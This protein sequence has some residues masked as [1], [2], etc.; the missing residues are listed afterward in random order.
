[1]STPLTNEEVE[2]IE[3]LQRAAR[4][5]THYD[6]LEIDQSAPKVEVDKAYKD[7]VRIWHPD[8][9]FRRDLGE[10]KAALDEN[11]GRLTEAHETLMN[12]SKRS[13]YDRELRRKGLVPV[14]RPS[15]SIMEP[16][17]EEVIEFRRKGATVEIVPSRGGSTPTVASPP[18]AP[19]FLRDLKDQVAQRMAKARVYFEG[20][21]ES[22][23]AANWPQAENNFYLATRYDP[24]NPEYVEAH[25]NAVS[26]SRVGRVAMC[27]Q[28]GDTAASYGRFKE[29]IA[30]Y[31][32][33]C[34]FEPTNGTAY[35]KLGQLLMSTEDDLR[36]A[37]TAW[38]KAAQLEPRN[39]AYHW[40]L[41]EAYE[42]AGLKQNAEKEARV[43]LELEPKNG[44]AA[45]LLKRVR[46]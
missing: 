8:G 7:L 41:A 15:K 14:P 18:P 34:E 13:A 25:K 35:F 38:R 36:G 23:A 4:V 12:D 17:R 10:W 26:H 2:A 16:P 20:G 19:K 5:G 40:A 11:F 3:R 32:K 6:V 28:Q 9:F 46:T 45:A 39:V 22:A 44:D 37:V 29:A 43:V 24:G 31:Q 33:A 27:I 42:K 30:S 1:M 21:K